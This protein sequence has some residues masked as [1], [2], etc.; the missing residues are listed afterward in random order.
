L[1]SRPI[2]DGDTVTGHRE[3]VALLA[4]GAALALAGCVGGPAAGGSA[5]AAVPPAATVSPPPASQ[6]GI[7]A[8]TT[9]KVART[10]G[11][12]HITMS[13][14]GI[15]KP[16]ISSDAAY[17]LCL[18]GVAGCLPEPPTE[19]VLALVTDTAY[20]TTS[21]AGVD[22]QNLKNT[23]VWAIS[24]LGSSQCVFSGGGAGGPAG[25]MPPPSAPQSQPLCDSIT[26]VNATTGAFIYNVA[27]AHQ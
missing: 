27:Y 21:S 4:L 26:F 3:W 19:I 2:L 9:L 13:P 18:K 1:R 10:L 5:T 17:Q 16:A 14:P 23:L 7:P 6:A 12:P 25:S 8:G 24:W 11:D 15:A 20:G 22:T